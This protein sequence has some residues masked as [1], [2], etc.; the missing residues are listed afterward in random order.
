MSID[1]RWMPAYSHVPLAQDNG[2]LD[3]LVRGDYCLLDDEEFFRIANVD[4]MPAFFMSMVSS[5]DHW[6]YIASNG[7]LSCGRRDANG[8]LFPYYSAD[9]LLD[10]QASAGPKTL[11]RIHA[12]DF[13]VE[14]LGSA[15]EALPTNPVCWQPLA[16]VDSSFEVQRC[17][18]KNRCGSRIVFEETNRTLQLAFRYQWAFSQ[19]FGFIR[20][21]TLVNLSDQDREVVVLDGI[22]NL[23][24]PGTDQ[25][26]QMRFSNLTDAYKKS[27]LV[28]PSQMGVFYLSSIPTDRAEPSEGLLATVAWQSGLYDPLVLLS[29]RQIPKFVRGGVLQTE[30]DV[31]G[32]RHCFFVSQPLILESRS[33]QSWN[34]VAD[35]NQ[36]HSD[37]IEKQALIVEK[38]DTMDSL[39]RTD[40][41][42]NE[43]TLL[44]YASQA[45]GL[46]S[47]AIPSRTNRHLSNT[48]FN[49]MRGGLPIDGYR[50]D[51]AEFIEHV[52]RCN[53]L[54]ANAYQA[55]LNQLPE[56]LERE[57]LEA[58]IRET[59]SRDL[60]RI[61]A[62][63]LPLTFSR[64]HGDPTRPWNVFQIN[65][66]DDKGKRRIGYEG[67]WRDIFQN[68]E[69][70]SLSFPFYLPAMIFRFVNASTLDG[71]NPYRLSS[72]GYDWERVH[73]DDAWASFGYWGDH[74]IVYLLKLLEAAESFVP[75]TLYRSLQECHCVYADIPY[76]IRDC[77][78]IRQNPRQSIGYDLAV[79]QKIQDRVAVT[80][81][82]GQLACDQAGQIHYVSLLEKLLLTSMVKLCNY[83][84]AG[85]VWLNTQRPEWNDAQNALAGNGASIVT[86]CY[87]RKFLITVRQLLQRVS[88]S[89]VHLSAE[90]ASFIE[91]LD[92][93]F[94]SDWLLR[95]SLH[96]DQ[97]RSVLVDQL[98]RAAEQHR[99][100]VYSGFSGSYQCVPNSTLERLLDSAEQSL[101]ET[102]RCSRRSD[103][104]FHS[105]NLLDFQPQSI[106]VQHLEEMLEGQVAI[107][108]SGLLTAS[109]ASQ[110]LE[111]LRQSRLYR[112]D[113]TSFLLYPDREMPRLLEKN[114]I[115]H[116]R[117]E[118]LPFT[119]Q[120]LAGTG[121]DSLI[122]CD[123]N[124]NY[125]FAGSLRNAEDL[126]SEISKLAA[127]SHQERR[128]SEADCRELCQLWEETFR[129]RQFTGRS[130]TFFA[131]EGL[132]S[133][134]WHMVSK[135]AL[136]A[137]K[138]S[139]KAYDEKDAF[140]S[141][142]LEQ[143]RSINAG[144]W[145]NKSPQLYGAF[146]TDPYSHTPR[147]AGAQQP[148][149]TGQVKEDIL[150]R[151]LEIGVR[152]RNGIMSIGP[153]WL[154]PSE[155]LKSSGK[156][157]FID[158]AGQPTSL[159]LPCD[160]FGFTI[161]QVPV[162]LHKAT[163]T[164]TH[165]R[166][167]YHHGEIRQH[168][169][170]HLTAEESEQIFA[171]SGQIQ[172]IEAYV[173]VLG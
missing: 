57:E 108:E 128:L 82:D 42:A 115:S 166:V 117:W 103:G 25:N 135:L 13:A 104:L 164:Q 91:Q 75:E 129:H 2:H 37:L 149:M 70:M 130:S 72:R 40:I 4:Q 27:E 6:M 81:S 92:A 20:T 78:S 85:G 24:S 146:P 35:V 124:G 88:D 170:G 167:Y 93:I 116:Q 73:P 151:W 125:H 34:I 120:A 158:L 8:A 76:R 56:Q 23:R 31:R 154:E 10:M 100:L 121:R 44:R 155:F 165:V 71:Y 110:L 62:E 89:K 43:A 105:F 157:E 156:L 69:A 147:H 152:C 114:H 59:G 41:Q 90:V 127:K 68:W 111:S 137:A 30:E 145:R 86:V 83:V 168:L 140:A 132:G 60:M 15:N 139:L 29:N 53:A 126:K 98:Q 19:Q 28:R 79:E 26:F 138:C 67:N 102:L 101:N 11:I 109:E 18:F 63:F 65:T 171:R 153:S 95:Q 66:R 99:R 55:V 58:R 1:Q 134:Y 45:D 9:K 94:Q 46:Q 47:G 17:I 77:V 33:S 112:E 21:A 74:Q 113:Q 160:S 12:S 22:E 52:G 142:L 148:G 169:G 173:E 106:G 123:V 133:I 96:S 159:Q 119:V 48:L 80:G 141:R 107:L 162:I 14:R 5:E 36:D 136:A 87:L 131:Y 122:R 61:A 3:R 38:S 51:R 144:I 161:C 84:P 163:N 49:T 32:Q 16:T 64:R 150:I 143:F 118:Q 54:V 97:A 172:L 7:A 39:L 50:I